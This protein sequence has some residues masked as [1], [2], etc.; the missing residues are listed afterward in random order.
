MSAVA[1]TVGLGMKRASTAIDSRIQWVAGFVKYEVVVTAVCATTPFVLWL[2]GGPHRDSI[3]AYYDMPDAKLFYVPLTGAALLFIVN[4]V[5]KE[6]THWYN[7]WLGLAL[8]A[9]VLFDHD[10]GSNV[11]HVPAAAAFFGGNAVVFVLFTPWG[12]FWAKVFL[13]LIMVVAFAGWFAFHWY[14]LF[15][16]ESFSLWVIALHFLLEALGL[17]R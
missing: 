15:W 12:E 14:S 4:G 8:L 3:S 10:G 17:I 5:V 16:A 2:A 13:A 7:V 11:I 6:K 1:Q 9:V